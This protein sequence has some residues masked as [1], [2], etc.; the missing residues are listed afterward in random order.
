[1][2]ELRYRARGAMSCADRVQKCR[3]RAS[4]ASIRAALPPFRATSS[5]LRRERSL[6]IY[7]LCVLVVQPGVGPAE[8]PRAGLRCMFGLVA[9]LYQNQ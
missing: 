3:R 2:S 1:M 8:A 9:A 7:R 5:C 4:E 6:E